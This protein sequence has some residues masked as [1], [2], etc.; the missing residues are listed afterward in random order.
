MVIMI[1]IKNYIIIFII[2][3]I[4]CQ[5][6]ANIQN[7]TPQ[8]EKNDVV[9][10][11]QNIVSEQINKT[12]NI[13]SENISKPEETLPENTTK[14]EEIV[15]IQ[16]TEEQKD[17]LISLKKQ[18]ILEEEQYKKDYEIYLKT[19]QFL[20]SLKDLVT[21][22]ENQ[23]HEYK[24]SYL[25]D[26]ESRKQRQIELLNR[27]DPEKKAFWRK[28]V[29]V[30][31]P[32][33]IY[34]PVQSQTVYYICEVRDPVKY[35]YNFDFECSSKPYSIKK[36]MLIDR[37]FFEEISLFEILPKRKGFYIVFTEIQGKKE[38]FKI[39]DK[40]NQ[41]YNLSYLES[42]G[43]NLIK[44]YAYSIQKVENQKRIYFKII[45]PLEIFFRFIP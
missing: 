12:E 9:K 33:V 28:D 4:S 40:L 31:F 5:T 32:E 3:L 42:D 10:N 27:I 15:P 36:E 43:E 45:S 39:Y 26:L 44:L 18:I 22:E 1:N 37:N 24:F 14:P 11:D 8:T 13:E 20:L 21:K 34:I 17:Y 35:L 6:N 23:F 29:D 19:K 38:T 41:E 25:K 16:P 7:Q 30:N 2:F